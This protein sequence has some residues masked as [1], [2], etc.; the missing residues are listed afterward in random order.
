MPAAT[1]TLVTASVLNKLGIPEPRPAPAAPRFF[2]LDDRAA[3]KGSHGRLTGPRAGVVYAA[4]VALPPDLPRSRMG[5]ATLLEVGADGTLRVVQHIR[6]RDWAA[7]DVRALL[8]DGWHCQAAVFGRSDGPLLP[9]GP[10][11]LGPSNAA[12]STQ[13][14][15]AAVESLRSAL[16]QQ[17]VLMYRN[18][19]SD[20]YQDFWSQVVRA[21]V[22]GQGTQAHLHVD[23]SSSD[24]GYLTSLALAAHAAV[25]AAR[26]RPEA[27]LAAAA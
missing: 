19:G 24:D 11:A 7:H 18:D 20:D 26:S 5:V 25:V 8:M 10:S 13:P 12:A 14:A 17:R 1:L 2:S 15:G 16:A 3:L 27:A 21:K 9:F 22:A 4:G 23:P 6:R